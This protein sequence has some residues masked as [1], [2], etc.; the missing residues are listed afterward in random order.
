M[1]D[2]EPQTEQDVFFALIG[3][4]VGSREID[5]RA[6]VQ[7]EL[8]RILAE[9]NETLTGSLAASLKLTAGDEVQ[10]LLSAPE[11]AVEVIVRIADRFHP[12][13]V[14]WG[15]GAGELTTDLADDVATL[16]GPCFHRAREA[17]AAA[18]SDETWLGVDGFPAPP[19]R[20]LS[21]LFRLM[22]RVR[23]GW[24]D[25]QARYVR[26]VRGRLQKD[27]AAHFE[28]HESTISKVLRAACYPELKGGE[29]AA[30]MLLEWLGEA[31]RSGRWPTAASEDGVEE[32]G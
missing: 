19:G 15:L 3:D 24:T 14:I 28:V 7:N 17:L 29:R 13:A 6:G 25:T 18:S 31:C 16:D 22:W 12:I 4:I 30:R 32:E 11:V 8:R 20:A 2:P 27:V 9:L 21:A 1:A 23:S 10:G 5:E 26:E